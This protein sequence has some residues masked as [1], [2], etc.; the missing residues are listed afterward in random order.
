ML[1]AAAAFACFFG[2]ALLGMRL[3][4]VLPSHH[5]SDESQKLLQTSLGIVGT[6]AGLVL[7][8]LV[9]SATG[10]Y[11]AQ[12]GELMDASSK[13]VLLDRVLAQYGPQAQPARAALRAAVQHTLDRLWPRPGAG[14]PNADPLASSGEPLFDQIEALPETMPRQQTLK[15]QAVN[16]AMQLGQVRWL[17]F[18]Q[19]VTSIS[20]PLLVLL[21]FWFSIS[22]VGLGLFGAPNSTTMVALLLASLA[23]SGAILVILGLSSPFEGIVRLPDTP[24]REAL[25][26][27][28]AK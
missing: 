12:R 14:E 19:N 11:N 6:I 17:M 5:L 21:I 20:M 22:F 2:G 16:L 26:N 4:S 7:G 27:L 1:I 15:A 10:S 13:V 25:A 8:L 23:V 9:A 28:G 3:R 18:V 24:L